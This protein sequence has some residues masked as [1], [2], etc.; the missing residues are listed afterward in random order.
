MKKPLILLL[1]LFSALTLTQCSWLFGKKDDELELPPATQEGKGTLGFMLNG[2]LWVPKGFTGRSNSSLSYDPGLNGGLLTL[3]AYRIEGDEGQ[4]ITIYCGGVT[5]IGAYALSRPNPPGGVV[6]FN[7]NTRT[8]TACDYGDGSIVSQQGT[9]TI[10]RFDLTKHIIAGR[11]EF[12]LIHP[13]CDTIR[14][15]D[16]RF[17]MELQ[18]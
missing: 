11:V 1:L 6:Y 13:E 8:N 16:G 3:S 9:L 5:Q 15:T 17:D 18:P 12:T 7:S 2:K 10:T 4:Y 14:A